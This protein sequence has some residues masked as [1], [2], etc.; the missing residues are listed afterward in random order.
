[1]N[2]LCVYCPVG[3]PMLSNSVARSPQ[4]RVCESLLLF[5]FYFCNLF[6]RDWWTTAKSFKITYLHLH[7]YFSLY[8][9]I[10]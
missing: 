10:V 4:L 3:N 7:L 6:V 2:H 1:M 9:N 8:Q 5:G